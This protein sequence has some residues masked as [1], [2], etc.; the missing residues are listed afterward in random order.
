[1]KAAILTTIGIVLLNSCLFFCTKVY[2]ED[3]NAELCEVLASAAGNFMTSR[4]NGVALS[5]ALSVHKTVYCNGDFP[6]E[7]CSITRGMILDAYRFPKFN[8]EGVQQVT[9]QEFENS[10]L[11]DCLDKLVE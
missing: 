10:W 8:T 3:Q 2:A 6:E 9:I 1:M 5:K 4:Q 11:L 7:L